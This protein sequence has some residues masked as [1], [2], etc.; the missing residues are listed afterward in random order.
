ML[1]DFFTKP[2][3]GSLFEKFREAIMGR[4]HIGTLKK[5]LPL[6]PPQERV[7][8]EGLAGNI[9]PSS[10]NGHGRL[11]DTPPNKK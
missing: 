1:A 4:K 2:L 6:S 7:E 11:R 10:D 8:N 9:G 3:Q 5:V